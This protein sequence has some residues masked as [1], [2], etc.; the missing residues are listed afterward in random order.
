MFFSV[1]IHLFKLH[2]IH[3]YL[4]PRSFVRGNF[5]FNN[6]LFIMYLL[7]TLIHCCYKCIHNVCLL[8]MTD[9]VLFNKLVNY[10]H[11][12]YLNHRS[13]VKLHAHVRGTL[14]IRRVRSK[15]AAIHRCTLFYTQRPAYILD[16]FK[17][18]M[19]DIRL[20]R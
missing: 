2:A 14:G 5:I 8:K 3:V 12:F 6:N 10:R 17:I 1:V 7:I 9:C 16:M 11:I 13:E 20:I 18:V 15:Y 19:L 4:P